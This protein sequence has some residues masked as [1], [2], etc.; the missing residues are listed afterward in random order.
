MQ[1][2]L[3]LGG[4]HN[5]DGG[6][7]LRV[8]KN[9]VGCRERHKGPVA[10]VVE[11][12]G[13]VALAARVLPILTEFPLLEAACHSGDSAYPSLQWQPRAAKIATLRIVSSAVWIK[14]CHLSH[15]HPWTQMQQPTF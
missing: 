15:P 11:C 2:L 7:C 8:G 3:L 4:R 1:G 9:N 10:I 13:G 5:F 6:F 14:V 12:P